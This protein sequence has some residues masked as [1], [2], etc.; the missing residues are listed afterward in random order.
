VVMPDRVDEQ[1]YGDCLMNNHGW[2]M[3]HLVWWEGL[4]YNGYW[5]PFQKSELLGAKN[6]E[7]CTQGQEK[8]SEPFSCTNTEWKVRLSCHVWSQGLKSGFIFLNHS[9]KISE[10]S[11]ATRGLQRSRN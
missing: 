2:A 8:V 5:D 10:W 9:P 3:L 4:C 1:I 6:V 7:W 11:C